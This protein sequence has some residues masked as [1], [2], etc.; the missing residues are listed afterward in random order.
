MVCEMPV[1]RKPGSPSMAMKLA[2]GLVVWLG[3][4]SVKPLLEPL[5]GPHRVLG[6]PPVAWARGS[7]QFGGIGGI[8]GD[9]RAVIRP[10]EELGVGRRRVL[11]D[12]LVWTTLSELMRI[13][14]WSPDWW[15]AHQGDD[16]EHRGDEDGDSY[17]GVS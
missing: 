5:S 4:V 9:E 13:L 11:G 10:I 2:V 14:C 15:P 6:A 12:E 3:L 17:G 16:R 7:D 8:H 1:P